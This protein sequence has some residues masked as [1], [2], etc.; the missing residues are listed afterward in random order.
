MLR[1]LHGCQAAT[2]AK[3]KEVQADVTKVEQN[4]Q[5]EI[6]KL[7]RSFSAELTGALLALASRPE[8]LRAT[9][10]SRRLCGVWT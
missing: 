10:P 4:L 8:P 3:V 2:G 5:K 1:R 9:I 7:N 6:G